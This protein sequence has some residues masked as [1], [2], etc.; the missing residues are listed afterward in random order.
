MKKLIC[1][2]SLL[3]LLGYLT[4]SASAMVET[5]ETIPRSEEDMVNYLEAIKLEIVHEEPRPSTIDSFDVN[6]D[7]L[8]VVGDLDWTWASVYSPEGKFLYG[9]KFEIYGS[10]TVFWNGENVCIYFIRS[11]ILATFDENGTCL[12]FR[13]LTTGAGNSDFIKSLNGT[14]E[15]TVGGITYKMER[16]IPVLGYSRIVAYEDGQEPRILYDVTQ[17]HNVHTIFKITLF[18]G[19]FGICGYY[20]SKKRRNKKKQS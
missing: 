10:H 16:D 13:E 14:T 7:G 3:I 1:F 5:L 9:Y 17:S 15:R 12:D 6:Q 20:S 11:G 4:P 19:W 8:L 18:L 2:V